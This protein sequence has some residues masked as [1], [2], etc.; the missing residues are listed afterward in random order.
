MKKKYDLHIKKK[1]GSTKELAHQNI[2]A[3]NFIVPQ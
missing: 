1:K 3:V 2:P